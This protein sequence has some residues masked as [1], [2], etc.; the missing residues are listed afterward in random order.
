MNDFETYSA[1]MSKVK[2]LLEMRKF[3][4]ITNRISQKH[5]FNEESAFMLID[6]QAA[7]NGDVIDMN[8][9]CRF[10]LKTDRNDDNTGTSRV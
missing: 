10:I 7:A 1:M 3:N 6:A 2:S 9:E 4:D 5:R 8:K